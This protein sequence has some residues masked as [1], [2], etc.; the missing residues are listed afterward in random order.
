M[1]ARA[2]E[3]LDGSETVEEEIIRLSS[4]NFERMPM[5]EV[6]FDRYVLSLATAMKS[7]AGLPVD[8]R[9]ESFDYLTCGEAMKSLPSPSLSALTLAN[10]WN[11]S[12]LMTLSPDLLFSTLEILLGGREA[13]P[14]GWTPRSFTAIER[15]FGNRL[16]RLVLDEFALCF[17]QLSEVSFEIESLES[18]PEAVA[19]APVSSPCV[20]VTLY[21]TLA[22]RGGTLS[23]L[24]PYTAL[25]NVRLL[26]SQPFLGGKLG[27]DSGW[28]KDL[29]SKIEDTT[30]TLT[31]HLHSL[32]VPVQEALGWR[33]GQ[34]IDLGIGPDQP[35]DVICGDKTMFR[36]QM[37][38]R[39]TG[40]VALRLTEEKVELEAADAD[41]STD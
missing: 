38:R 20:R 1:N 37:G 23:F 11:G 31:A 30:V 40:Q 29:E 33:K 25:E 17:R 7:F 34:T 26:L 28:R 15:R 22:E 18:S 27:G 5:L 2:S 41:V 32:K 10:P 6:M 9:L 12:L 24:I 39:A 16:A 8:V 36:G 21:L 13:R 3:N 19:L 4:L 35:V 14:K